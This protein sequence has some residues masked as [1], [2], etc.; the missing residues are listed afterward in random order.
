MSLKEKG[1]WNELELEWLLSGV[2]TY[3]KRWFE[4]GML[5][6]KYATENTIIKKNIYIYNQVFDDI[7]TNTKRLWG[8]E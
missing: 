7:I 3:S 2:R 4:N 8:L 5:V 1:T 6:G